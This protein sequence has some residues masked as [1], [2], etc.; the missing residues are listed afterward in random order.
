MGHSV[1]HVLF[2]NP[3]NNQNL[4]KLVK[5]LLTNWTTAQARFQSHCQ[6]KCEMHNTSALRMD[7]FIRTMRR[8]TIPVNQ[9]LDNVLQQQIT[10]NRQILSSLFK[11]IIACGQNNIPLRRRR[12]DD[13]SDLTLQGNF[14]TL[15]AIRVDS[16]D[17]ILQQHLE[18]APRNATYISKTIQNEMITTVSWKVY[19]R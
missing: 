13:P 17:K 9:Q 18:T 12:D 15:F 10:K 4:D 6:G 11:T 8:Q 7:N 5:S 14:Q 1:S 2:G 3:R 16:G 19:I